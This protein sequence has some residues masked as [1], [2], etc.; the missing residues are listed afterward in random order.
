MMSMSL[1]KAASGQHNGLK[2]CHINAWSLCTNNFLKVD[3]I[4]SKLCIHEG[5]DII[6]ISETW[7]DSTIANN[8]ITPMGYTAFRKDRNR[9]GG[10]IAILVSD[11]LAVTN[12]TDISSQNL[13]TVVVEVL[14]KTKHIFVI[15]CYWPPGATVEQVDLL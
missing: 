6:C 11:D 7:L 14:I 8:N 1:V 9:Q 15:C 5:Y 12:R 2:I 13:E 3:E 10:G 4:N